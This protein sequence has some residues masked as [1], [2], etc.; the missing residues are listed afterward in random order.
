MIKRK[1]CLKNGN[2][3]PVAQWIRRR[4]PEPK[5]ARSNRAGR[6]FKAKVKRKKAKSE[7]L[8]LFAFFLLHFAFDKAFVAQWIEQTSPKGKIGVRFP[9]G[10]ISPL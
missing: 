6:S 4:P 3:A 10:A 9:A 8:E 5:I 2:P 7:G 1:C